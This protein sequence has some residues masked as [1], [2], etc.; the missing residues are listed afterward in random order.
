[1]KQP[2]KI[3]VMALIAMFA[4]CN[5]ANAQFGSLRGLANKAKKAVKEKVDDTKNSAKSNVMQQ[6]ESTS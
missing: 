4:L 6:A 2:I 5:G 1:M 3:S